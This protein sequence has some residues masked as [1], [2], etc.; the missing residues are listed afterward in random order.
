MAL[1]L[2]GVL[3][4]TGITTNGG[5]RSIPVVRMPSTSGPD[6]AT[7]EP[8][9]VDPTSLS[10]TP[11][12]SPDGSD[13]PDPTVAPEW[14]YSPDS[15]SSPASPSSTDAPEQTAPGELIWNG[16]PELGTRVFDGLERAPGTITVA[17]DPQQRYGRSFR[18]E[19]WENADGTKARCESRGLRRPNGSV[20]RL[21]SDFEGRTLYLGWRSLWE[22]M[23]TN[24]HWIAVF[25]LH[26]SGVGSGGLNVGPFVLRTLGDGRLYF[27][28]ISP[29][30]SDRHIWSTPL[31]IGS[32]NSF[33]IGFRLSRNDRDGWV[34][35]WYNG[36]K[37][38][39]SNNSTRYPGATLWG[40]HVNVKWGVYR[41]GA[42]RGRAVAYLNQAGLGTSYSAVAL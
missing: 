12:P 11:E 42:N 35:F 13:V 3:A 34:E 8:S 20:L 36:E 5:G 21:G 19:T 28:H 15:P 30:G 4:F 1:L 26:V 18:Y 24:G 31:P 33:V 23:P 9:L 22:P 25:Q 29:D 2:C 17:D 40:T 6:E 27:Q 7:D 10:D 39:L 38:T 32:W 16:D 14:P 37:Q 41:S